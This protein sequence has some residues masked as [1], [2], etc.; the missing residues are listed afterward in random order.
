MAGLGCLEQCLHTVSKYPRSRATELAQDKQHLPD[1]PVSMMS[2]AQ[3]TFYV[4]FPPTSL[5]INKIDICTSVE[6]L[7][8]KH[9]SRSA[10][11]A[12]G[13]LHKMIHAATTFFPR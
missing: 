11:S 4:R 10:A 2:G 13:S 8:Q 5:T 1:A 6:K 3:S 12:L 9:S 7:R